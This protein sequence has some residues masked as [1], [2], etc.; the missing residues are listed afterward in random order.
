M[1]NQQEIELILLK[2]PHRM[3]VLF[4]VY[5][6]DDVIDLIKDEASIK[7]L[8]LVKQ[9]LKDPASVTVQE[10]IDAAYAAHA[11]DY[12]AHAAAYV[13]AN[14]SKDKE[15]KLSQYL[16]HLKSMIKDL[17]KLEKAIWELE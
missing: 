8:D 7:T 5:C 14:A 12:V 1:T 3:Q 15:K 6:C 16:K 13:A 17:S 2:L 11:A 10:L 9:W 4:A